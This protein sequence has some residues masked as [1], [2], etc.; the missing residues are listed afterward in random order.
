[1]HNY[2]DNLTW[3]RAAV[4]ILGHPSDHRTGTSFLYEGHPH[5]SLLL[6][7]AV[8]ATL[9]SIY[10]L[11]QRKLLTFSQTEC[12][13]PGHFYFER[14]LGPELWL[15]VFALHITSILVLTANVEVM[16]CDSF[17]GAPLEMLKEKCVT[18]W[19]SKVSKRNIQRGNLYLQGWPQ[20]RG[21]KV[22]LLSPYKSQG[23][24]RHLI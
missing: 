20:W 8:E 6:T 3:T 14:F 24:Y 15:W 19:P 17:S 21:G 16:T 22:C 18:R 23:L 4:L 11:P 5:A 2:S 9:E 13:A 12:L 10:I 1:M 7:F